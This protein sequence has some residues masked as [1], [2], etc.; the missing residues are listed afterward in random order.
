MTFWRL[1][2]HLVWATKD[3]EYLIQSEMEDR[4]RS[5]IVNKCCCS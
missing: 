2:Y 5:Y 4:L 1:Y 3:R